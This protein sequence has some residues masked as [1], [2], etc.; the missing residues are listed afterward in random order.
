MQ[1]YDQRY[2]HVVFSVLTVSDRENG[3]TAFLKRNQLK[4]IMI[5][6]SKSV[7]PSEKDISPMRMGK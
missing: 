6:G 3:P 5:K 7:I 2:R 4:S 1:R